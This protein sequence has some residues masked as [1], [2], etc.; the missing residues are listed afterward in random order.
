MKILNFHEPK[1]NTRLLK[2]VSIFELKTNFCWK[3]NMT[4]NG[5]TIYHVI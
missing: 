2:T 1:S 4:P 3:D 5:M